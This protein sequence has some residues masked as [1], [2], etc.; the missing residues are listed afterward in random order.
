M[1]KATATKAMKRTMAEPASV[2][3]LAGAARSGKGAGKGAGSGDLRARVEAELA[4]F[5][6][7]MTRAAA[8]MGEGVSGSTLSLWLGGTYGG[9]V[10]A[11]EARI[12]RW[13]ET[14]A[15][16]A[17]HAFGGAR[18]DAHAGTGTARQIGA[19][20]AY[21]Q[22]AGDLALVHG[23]SGRGKTWCAQRHCADRASAYRLRASPTMTTLPR[24]LSRLAATV[25]GGGG[26]GSSMEAETA[27]V[28]ALEGR[29]ALVVVDEAHHLRAAL[30]DELRCIRD[31]AG[32]GLA[33]IGDDT[34]LM[35]LARCP[36]VRGRIGMSVDLKTVTR[37]DVAAIA[38]GPLGR[39]ATVR[40]M[41]HLV[42]AAAGPGGLHSLRRLLARGWM[43]ARGDQREAI[44]E[45]DIEAAAGEVA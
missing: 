32:C 18:L 23:P 13:L 30:I 34:I 5:G 1:T 17:A 26:Y 2:T 40:E 27:I 45:A 35:T 24:L 41:K 20:L 19:A 7:S 43:T 39:K 8:E 6:L 36:Q 9:N 28:A 11:V 29:G 21:A 15:E 31:M 37:D 25:A 44:R 14:R 16:R 10:A 12:M 33:L 3:P 42:A 4:A 38:A 22:A